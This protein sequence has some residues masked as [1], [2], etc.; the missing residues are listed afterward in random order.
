P[1][2]AVD[3]ERQSLDVW[4]PDTGRPAPA[5][6][7]FHGGGWQRGGK[8]DLDAYGGLPRELIRRGYAFV[9]A[10]YRLTPRAVFPAQTEDA[11]KAIRLVRG[12]AREW[13]IDASRI[14]LMGASAGAHLALWAGF[15]EQPERVRCILD[16]WGLTDFRVISPRLPRGDA[17]TAFFATSPGQY[18]QPGPELLD[19]MRRAS[20]IEYVSKSSPPVFIVHVGPADLTGAGDPRISGPNT[21]VHSAKFGLLLRDRLRQA[22]VEHQIHIAPDVHERW[23]G[24]HALALRF[25][26]RYLGRP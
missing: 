10:G 7:E 11:M 3:Q 17:L 13:N 19:A 12:R 20:P 5:V 25:L 16:F 14:A 23:G 4:L 1:Y 18:E 26:E 9:S 24:Y 21:N 8:G 2:G 6:I 15:Q 22:G